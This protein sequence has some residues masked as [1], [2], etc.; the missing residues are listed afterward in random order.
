[1]SQRCGHR[2][3]THAATYSGRAVA[4]AS[5]VPLDSGEDAAVMGLAAIR[6]ARCRGVRRVHEDEALRPVV[7]V[8]SPAA[9]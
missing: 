9:G 4:P 7:A 1:M 5:H 2:V 3:Q 8:W 6:S